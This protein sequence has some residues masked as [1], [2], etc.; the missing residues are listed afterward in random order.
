M[1]GSNSRSGYQQSMYQ[2]E[3]LMHRYEKSWLEK[4]GKRI[5]IGIVVIF[6]LYNWGCDIPIINIICPMFKFLGKIIGFASNGLGA[7]GL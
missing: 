1:E 2:Q 6:I 7:I 4:N 3:P 5:L